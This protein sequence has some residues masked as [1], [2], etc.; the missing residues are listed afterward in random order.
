MIKN[1][2]H[3]ATALYIAAPIFNTIE[4]NVSNIKIYINQ[5]KPLTSFVF[6]LTSQ[7]IPSKFSLFV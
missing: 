5:K 4:I 6:P 2:Y 7:K 3:F 1:A